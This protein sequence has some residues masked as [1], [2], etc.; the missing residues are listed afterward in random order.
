VPVTSSLLLLPAVVAGRMGARLGATG[1]TPPRLPK[2]PE[3]GTTDSS[4]CSFWARFAV[5][6]VADD[7]GFIASIV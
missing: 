3:V 2:T 1:A 5:G 6:F 7:V 4:P